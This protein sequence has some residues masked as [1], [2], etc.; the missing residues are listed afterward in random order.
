M[1]DTQDR[2]SEWRYWERIHEHA[3]RKVS[4]HKHNF[5]WIMHNVVAHPLLGIAPGAKTVRFH[6]YTSEHLNLDSKVSSSMPVIGNRLA[7]IRHNVLGH[8]AI[9]LWP[10][11]ATFKYHDE[12]AEEMNVP[13]WV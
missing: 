7:W 11:E 2:G 3:W 12:T 1:F 6:D 9:G 13:N 4:V 5:W 8:L 10:S